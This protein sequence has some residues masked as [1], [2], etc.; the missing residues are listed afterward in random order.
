MAIGEGNLNVSTA[1]AMLSRY[2]RL[3]LGSGRELIPL[4]EEMEHAGTYVEIQKLKYG[5]AVDFRIEIDA[6]LRDAF[7]LKLIV[8][9]L[10]ENAILHG[11][12]QTEKQK[13]IVVCTVSRSGDSD[14]RI[15]VR[16]DAGFAEPA[17]I[18]DCIRE[19]AGDAG[20]GGYGLR[21][22]QERIHAYYGDRY[23]VSVERTRD[24]WTSVSILVPIVGNRGMPSVSE[25]ILGPET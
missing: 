21:N 7:C 11:I 12:L 19:P 18:E 9:P 1:I 22:V 10:V 15:E 6:G 24:G 16:D 23:G 20:S 2:Y 8:Q 3:G 13:G 4:H 25:P 5:D 14:L 17:K